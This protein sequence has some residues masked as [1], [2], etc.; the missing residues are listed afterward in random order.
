MKAETKF[1]TYT[2]CLDCF[3][4]H[5]IFTYCIFNTLIGFNKSWSMNSC[6]DICR[7]GYLAQQKCIETSVWM[8]EIPFLLILP[9]SGRFVSFRFRFWKCS[10]EVGWRVGAAF[11]ERSGEIPQLVVDPSARNVSLKKGDSFSLWTI[12]P[13]MLY[14]KRSCKGS[15]I[16]FMFNFKGGI[17]C[18]KP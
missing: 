14:F 12:F 1:C 5:Y 6:D 9:M 10:G 3:G 7:S 18:I 11:H 16:L 17:R 8:A 2:T 15:G 13:T 4:K